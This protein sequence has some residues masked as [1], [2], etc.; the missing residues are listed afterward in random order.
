MLLLI[1]GKWRQITIAIK[2]IAWHPEIL[3]LCIQTK[4]CDGISNHLYALVS[5]VRPSVP[6]NE[7]E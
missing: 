3:D 6:N 4:N 5:G 7:R 1:V 2:T